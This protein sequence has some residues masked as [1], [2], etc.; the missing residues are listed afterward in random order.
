MQQTPTEYM[1]Q[2]EL[3]VNLNV[4]DTI[5]VKTRRCGNCSDERNFRW[6]QCFFNNRPFTIF[7]NKN[8]LTRLVLQL[9]CHAVKSKHL[10]KYINPP[11]LDCR[12][13]SKKP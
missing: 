1:K 12:L 11:T 3:T 8:D 13:K 2:R 7:T 10:N 9:V 6:K 4:T 5:L